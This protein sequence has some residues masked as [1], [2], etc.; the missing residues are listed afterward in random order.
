MATRLLLTEN[1]KMS[2]SKRC[3]ILFCVCLAVSQDDEERKSE[4]AVRI[5]IY[6]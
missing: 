4:V 6:S 2:S 3:G 5:F 1:I